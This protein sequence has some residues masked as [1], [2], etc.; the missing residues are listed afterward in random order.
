MNCLCI[1]CVSGVGDNAQARKVDIIKSIMVRC[2]GSEAKYIVRSLQ[3]RLRI[4]ATETTVLVALAH[5]FAT[6]HSP[7]VDSIMKEDH[8]RKSKKNEITDCE[9]SNE[10]I[11]DEGNSMFLC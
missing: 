8:Q 11:I 3:G 2:Q 10:K 5:A 6:T 7:I 4:G 1:I 9:E